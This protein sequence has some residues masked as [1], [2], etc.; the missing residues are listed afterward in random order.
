MARSRHIIPLKRSAAR[1]AHLEFTPHP[2]QCR[3]LIASACA[4]AG[5]PT[6]SPARCDGV[7]TPDCGVECSAVHLSELAVG[8]FA[9]SADPRLRRRVFG[10]TASAGHHPWSVAIPAHRHATDAAHIR[11]PAPSMAGS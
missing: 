6:P 4:H 3:D 10:V 1:H 5:R 2:D 9:L 8:S 7:L 11:P